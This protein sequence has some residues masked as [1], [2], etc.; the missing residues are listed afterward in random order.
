MEEDETNQ[1]ANQ[2]KLARLVEESALLFVFEDTEG[3]HKGN[4]LHVVL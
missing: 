3:I 4:W 2:T 1:R